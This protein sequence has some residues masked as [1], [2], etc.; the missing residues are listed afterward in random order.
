[1]LRA[2][3]DENCLYSRYHLRENLAF[4]AT[5][6]QWRTEDISRSKFRLSIVLRAQNRPS[7]AAN[8]RQEALQEIQEVPGTTR[9]RR[10]GGGL[11]GDEHEDGDDKLAMEWYDLNVALWHGRTTGSWSDGEHW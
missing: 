6:M 5:T 3:S 9:E 4:D 11:K 1:M 7:E 10:P 8:L 2:N